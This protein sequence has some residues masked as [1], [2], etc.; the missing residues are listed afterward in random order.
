MHKLAI[1]SIIAIGI[2][3]EMTIS[4][5]QLSSAQQNINTTDANYPVNFTKLF[6][7]AQYQHCIPGTN[8]CVS[9]VEVL[10]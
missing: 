5:L 10:Y 4:N 3:L 9:T 8:I 6:S 2:F 7:D 1:L